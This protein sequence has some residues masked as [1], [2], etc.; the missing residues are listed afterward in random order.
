MIYLSIPP[1]KVFKKVVEIDEHGCPKEAKDCFVDLEDG[2]IIELQDLIKS[3]LQNMGRKSHI[4]LE[5]FT[6]Y[7][8]TP[9]N[10]EDYFL[11]YTP[12]HN[13]KYP[14]EVEPEVVMGKNVQKYNPGAHT[15]Y[16]SFWH[17]ELYLKAEKKLQ[18][19]EKMLEQK[20]NRQH[21]GDSP[22]PT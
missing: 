16:G 10:T 7:L 18:V 8:K 2:S 5:A 22:N 13:G 14:T 11:A 15:K 9:P 3:A 6:I 12:N 21:V 19:A 4:T 20:E 1:G 17:S